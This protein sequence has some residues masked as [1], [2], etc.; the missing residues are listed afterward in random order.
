MMHEVVYLNEEKVK[1]K[2]FEA[3]LDTKNVWYLDNSAS[4]HMSGN[5]EFFT[6]LDESITGMVR[7][8]DDSRIDIQG[9]GSICF[10]FANGERKVL[11]NVYYIPDLKSNIISLGQATEAGCE[12]RM[13]ENLLR[14]YDRLGG[15]LIETSR[16][17]NRL[18]KVALEIENFKCLQLTSSTESTKWHA[19]L[20]HIS[21]ETMKMMISKELVFGIPSIEVER[22]TCVSCL[23]GKQTRQSFPQS[24]SYR[25]T[26][27][28]EL[29]HGDL[30][31]PITP[32]TPSHKRYVFVIVDDY[33]RYMWTVLLK[34]KS[35]A[36]EKFKA[37]KKLVEQET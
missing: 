19:W 12:V 9:K 14:I 36:F 7:F 10:V 1:P 37:F 24:T 33:S 22:E 5:R 4:N 20:G 11:S 21:V 16:S 2:I 15:L 13:K 6:K 35:E 23:L 25:A 17:R 3:D 8:G 18:Y 29:I 31:G 34:E 32:S 28:L 26:Q 30:C 27:V